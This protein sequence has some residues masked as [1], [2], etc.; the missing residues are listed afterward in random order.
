VKGTRVL[1]A[2]TLAASLATLTFAQ[3]DAPRPGQPGVR[4]WNG[5]IL[6]PH[7]NL[8]LPDAAE[9]LQPRG[10]AL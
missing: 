7:E 4:V 1:V 10:F 3:E 2:V 6:A 8:M 5:D 9:P